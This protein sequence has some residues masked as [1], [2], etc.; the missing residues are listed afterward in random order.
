MHVFSKIF[1]FIA[2]ILISISG[3]IN[4]KPSDALYSNV[5]LQFKKPNGGPHF[6]ILNDVPFTGEQIFRYV[7]NDSVYS[8]NEFKNGLRQSTTIYN[9]DGSV[10]ASYLNKYINGELAGVTEFY[11]DGS[12]KSDWLQG[13]ITDDGFGFTKKWHPNGQLLFEMQWDQN[14]QY[15]GLMTKWDEEGNIIAQENY[16]HGVLLDNEQ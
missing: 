8:I 7:K 13:G 15:H 2:I 3:C 12:K 4:E 16:D 5:E 14:N 1:P 6:R 11:T 10:R 9:E